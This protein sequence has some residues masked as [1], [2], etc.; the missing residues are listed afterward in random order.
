MFFEESPD[1]QSLSEFSCDVAILGAGFAGLM[2]ARKLTRLGY[3][4]AVIEPLTEV[5]GGASSRN[6]GWLH[7]GTYHA[8]SIG[9]RDQARQVAERC[10]YGWEQ[11]RRD[12]P[13]ALEPEG[14][15][16]IAIVSED[17]VA[18]SARRW[19]SAGVGYRP[20]SARDLKVVV[21]DV[22]IGPNERPFLVDDLG[23]DVRVLAAR[24]G[25]EIRAAGG[26][27]LTGHRPTA[28]G[29]SSVQ[30]TG[31][32]TRTLH[33][34]TLLLATGYATSKVCGELGLEPPAIRLWRSHLIALP[35]LTGP[36]VFSV[37]G[38]H[39]A[40]I[41]HGPWSIAGLNEDAE[42]VPEPTFEPNPEVARRL[43]EA[44]VARFPR[45]DISAAHVTA[46]VKVDVIEAPNA[47]RSLNIRVGELAQ[48]V[49]Y[50][51]PGKMTE[52][53]FTADVVAREIVGRL[54]MPGVCDRPIDQRSMSVSAGERR[55]VFV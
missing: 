1:R 15:A 22:A 24:L 30:L 35:R 21:G 17:R 48:D 11:I 43:V 2:C 18:E 54:G 14:H 42:I 33:F 7:A 9:D 27:I 32:P 51:L 31:G 37:A 40:M 4:V 5:L 19:D 38:G 55:E 10:R 45:A 28:L 13:E 46:C 41:N 25:H 49:L 8:L 12:F 3:R 23:L 34:R 44:V 47:A 52:A 50:V 53:P 16:A 36:S 6:E 26:V 20:A 29:E 39:A